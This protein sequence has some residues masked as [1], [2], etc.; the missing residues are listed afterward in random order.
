MS[1][2]KPWKTLSSEVV[3]DQ[4]EI[5]I[6]K[7][8][9]LLPDGTIKQ[10][11]FVREDRDVA[12]V[13]CLTRNQEVVFVRQYRHGIQQITIELPAGRQSRHDISLEDTARRELLEETGYSGEAC[14]QLALWFSNAPASTGRIGIFCVPVADKVAAPKHNP[15]EVTEV[16]FVPLAGV[17]QM[18]DRGELTTIIGVAAVNYVIEHLPTA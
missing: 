9:C 1:E 11:K 8:V 14:Q 17:K 15:G 10:E 6:R 5:K 12:I 4:G 18:V 2:V 13:F 16:M 7:D 3:F